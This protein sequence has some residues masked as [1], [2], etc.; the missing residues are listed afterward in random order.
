VEGLLWTISATLI[1]LSSLEGLEEL[2]GLGEVEGLLWTISATLLVCSL[3][4]S[5][6]VHAKQ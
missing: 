1:H 2:E 3:G 4:E 6:V 5:C